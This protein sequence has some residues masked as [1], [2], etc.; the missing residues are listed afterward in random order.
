VSERQKI[1][2]CQYLSTTAGRVNREVESYLRRSRKG[3]TKGYEA[4]NKLST[5]PLTHLLFS[6]LSPTATTFPLEC[7]I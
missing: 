1:Q 7:G 6:T 2:L 5:F 4:K 3:G